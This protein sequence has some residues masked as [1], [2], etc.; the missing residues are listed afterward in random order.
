MSTLFQ[1]I[2]NNEVPSEKVFENER[3]IVIKDIAPKAPVH[4]LIIPKQVFKSFQEIDHQ[5][6]PIL[7]EVGEIAQEMARKFQVEQGYRLLTN[8]GSDAG[9]TIFHLHFHLIGGKPLKDMA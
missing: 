2:I 6:L 3:F 4:L 5:N 8:V 7:A 9:Q 1:K